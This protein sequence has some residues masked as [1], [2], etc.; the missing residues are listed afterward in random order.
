MWCEA[1]RTTSKGAQGSRAGQGFAVAVKAQMTKERLDSTVGLHPTSAEEFVL[2][3][4]PVR[5]YRGGFKLQ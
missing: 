2:M 5:R 3:T 4:T 1:P